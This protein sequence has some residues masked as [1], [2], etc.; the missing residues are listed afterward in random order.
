MFMKMHFH[1]PQE[2]FPK[3]EIP[4]RKFEKLTCKDDIFVLVSFQSYM[5]R[6]QA[7]DLL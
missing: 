3:S 6:E 4:E 2:K 1:E 5:Q 7:F